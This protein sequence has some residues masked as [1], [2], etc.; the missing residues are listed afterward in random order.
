MLL[1]GPVFESVEPW[2]EHREQRHGTYVLRPKRK[3]T[4]VF[5]TVA[6]ETDIWQRVGRWSSSVEQVGV[7]AHRGPGRASPMSLRLM[8]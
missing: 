2:N 8:L 3:L 5:R 7:N 1:R 6:L 4:R